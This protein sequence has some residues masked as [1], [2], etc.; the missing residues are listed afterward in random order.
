MVFLTAEVMAYGFLFAN[1]QLTEQGYYSVVG[2]RVNRFCDGIPV[3]LA[4]GLTD[5]G[6]RLIFF[7]RELHVTLAVTVFL[8]YNYQ[9]PRRVSSVGGYWGEAVCPSRRGRFVL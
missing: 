5:V 9:R 7:L 1:T 3:T 8:Y 2:H 4:R 6:L